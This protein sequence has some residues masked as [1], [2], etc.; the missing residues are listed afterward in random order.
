VN[1]ALCLSGLQKRAALAVALAL[2]PLAGCG[3]G[4]GDAPAPAVAPASEGAPETGFGQTAP[5]AGTAGEAGAPASA[6]AA[7]GATISA[8]EAVRLGEIAAA[9]NVN[10]SAVE[11][12]LS[13]AG[14]DRA[15]FD[16]ALFQLAMDP[17]NGPR[18]E[19]ARV[20]KWAALKKAKGK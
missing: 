8:E 15:A 18:Y 19:D 12:T 10:P 16:R 1:T 14:M 6:S 13:A 3:G 9:I 2:G 4:P 20:Q 7:A 11:E 5:A 17:D